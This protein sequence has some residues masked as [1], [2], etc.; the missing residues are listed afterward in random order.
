MLE[1][2][3][4]GT[5]LATESIAMDQVVRPI[6]VRLFGL[7][8]LLCVASLLFMG[9]TA[10]ASAQPVTKNDACERVNVTNP[11]AV[12][13]CFNSQP[14]AQEA[15]H[16]IHDCDFVQFRWI[17]IL[18]GQRPYDFRAPPFVASAAD[19]PS[20]AVI[21]EAVNMAHGRPSAFAACVKGNDIIGSEGHMRKC[22][23]SM[24]SIKQRS[25][26]QLDSCAAVYNL[27]VE[28]LRMATPRETPASNST[29]LQL[30]GPSPFD[31]NN[32]VRSRDNPNKPDLRSRDCDVAAKV[33]TALAGASPWASCQQYAAP[34]SAAHIK[35]C[36]RSALNAQM[37]CPD[38]RAAYERELAKAYGQ[39]PRNYEPPSCELINTVLAEIKPPPRVAVSNAQRESSSQSPRLSTQEES[40]RVIALGVAAMVIFA[41]VWVFYLVFRAR[42]L[43]AQARERI[44]LSVGDGAAMGSET[45]S[46]T[47]V[48]SETSGGGG[49]VHPTAGGY[50]SPSTTTVSSTVKERHRFFLVRDDGSEI[51]I[52]IDA[53]SSFPT[54][55]GQRLG[56]VYGT[57]DKS[58]TWV[59]ALYNFAT[60]QHIVLDA[61]I[62]ALTIDI[63]DFLTLAIAAIAVVIV[64]LVTFLA[65]NPIAAAIITG[66]LA[67][68]FLFTFGACWYL[69]SKRHVYQGID[70]A[71]AVMRQSRAS[72]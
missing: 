60:R 15:T 54:R 72:A 40:Q 34:T 17:G 5:I 68:I 28:G 7:L 37:S 14:G 67:I 61:T 52:K 22:V 63:R 30:Y 4:T 53:A 55:D 47:Y 39:L 9:A 3:E 24:V 66:L 33:V 12:F 36:G 8:R 11:S 65:V 43:S 48:S 32:V 69:Q 44:E 38:A 35:A 13:R 19:V 42:L 56:V 16:P 46:Q 23:Q 49:Y 27:Y 18:Q 62:K 1:V 64:A 21:A 58:Q 71:L 70:D 26:A 2:A 41:A 57:L 29:R 59:V 25:T 51:A 20:C 10:P 6:T 50:I 31:D 45:Y